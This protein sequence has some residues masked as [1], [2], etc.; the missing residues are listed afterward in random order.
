MLSNKSVQLQ[1]WRSNL[2]SIISRLI[3]RTFKPVVLK[4]WL[5]G[6]MWPARPSGVAYEAIFIGKKTWHFNYLR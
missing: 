1:L 5:A 3:V 2:W 4:P 6:H